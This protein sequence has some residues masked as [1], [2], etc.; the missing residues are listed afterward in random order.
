MYSMVVLSVFYPDKVSTC[1]YIK[2]IIVHDK[3]LQLCS[4]YLLEI[5]IS[6]YVI[7]IMM[8][9]CEYACI[10]TAIIRDY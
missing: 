10:L 7:N 4:K 6:I 5:L 2:Y 9:K 8:T 3:I 1:V